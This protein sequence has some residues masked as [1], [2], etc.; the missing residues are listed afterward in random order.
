MKLIKQTSLVMSKQ[1]ESK[2]M[3]KNKFIGLV[4]LSLTA[5]STATTANTNEIESKVSAAKK[6][7]RIMSSILE[8]SLQ[9]ALGSRSN[10]V[11]GS[12]FSRTRPVF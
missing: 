1:N 5:I 3:I 6:D 12:F 7:I 2:K 9:E 4:A 8:T 10:H 11:K